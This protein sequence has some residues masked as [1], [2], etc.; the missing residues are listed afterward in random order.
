MAPHTTHEHV[1]RLS[2]EPSSFFQR[3]AASLSPRRRPQ[4]YANSLAALATGAICAEAAGAVTVSLDVCTHSTHTRTHM[5]MRWA[6]L[7][8]FVRSV[9]VCE[10]RT[11]GHGGATQAV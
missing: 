5:H 1:S 8:R 9:C 11:N 6:H 10:G 3:L 2:G 7:T 4:A